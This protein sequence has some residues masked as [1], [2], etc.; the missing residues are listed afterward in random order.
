[1]CHRGSGPR[2]APRVCH[3][4][5][6]HRPQPARGHQEVDTLNPPTHLNILS[7]KWAKYHQILKYRLLVFVSEKFGFGVSGTWLQR[8]WMKVSTCATLTPLNVLTSMHWG[9]CTGRLHAAAMPEVRPGFGRRVLALLTRHWHS[10]L[11]WC[12]LRNSGTQQEFYAC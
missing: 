1:M 12:L 8:C 6:R 3:R 9:W 5:H 2:S 4:Y 7:Q 10:V 11:R